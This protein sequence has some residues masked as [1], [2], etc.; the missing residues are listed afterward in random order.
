VKEPRAAKR[1]AIQQTF[2]DSA[3][4][5]VEQIKRDRS[6]LA[7][8]LCGR[9]SHDVVWARSDIDVLVTI[10]DK[11]GDIER[12]LE[13]LTR[14]VDAGHTVILIEHH[15]D[16]IKTADHVIDLGPEGGHAGGRVVVTGTPEEIAACRASHTARFLKHHLRL[17]A[18]RANGR[19]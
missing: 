9:L 13:S 4:P 7:A 18:A 16:V 1:A 5:F 2:C 15:L 12:L 17:R 11:P 8:V 3:R 6:I 10:D 14:L 19:R